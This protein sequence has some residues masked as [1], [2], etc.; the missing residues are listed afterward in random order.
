VEKKHGRKPPVYYRATGTDVPEKFVK[1]GVRSIHRKSVSIDQNDC[2]GTDSI[3]N[4]VLSTGTFVNSS[5][6]STPAGACSNES[7]AEAVDKRAVDKTLVV[8]KNDCAGTD[9]A[10]DADPWVNKQI[11]QSVWD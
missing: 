11:D 10:N 3:D 6:S 8:N 2:T 7:S 9:L 4:G 5:D 1:G